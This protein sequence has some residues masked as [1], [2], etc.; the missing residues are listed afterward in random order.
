M[1]VLALMIASAAAGLVAA[2]YCYVSARTPA[3]DVPTRN[4]PPESIRRA[5]IDGIN[6]AYAILSA[7]E[8]RKAAVWTA[9]AVLLGAASGVISL[10]LHS[11]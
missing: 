2:Y 9:A 3:E 10:L 7:Q 6:E 11:H 1:I 5:I 8:N 4:G